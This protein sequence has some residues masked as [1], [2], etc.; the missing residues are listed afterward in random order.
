MTEQRTQCGKSTMVE[1]KEVVQA[2]AT[3]DGVV[4]PAAIN[5]KNP[6]ATHELFLRSGVTRWSPDDIG[7][8]MASDRNQLQTIATVAS[9]AH[10]DSRVRELLDLTEG[11]P[12][13]I[14]ML[15]A[16]CDKND[17]TDA[18]INGVSISYKANSRY[19]GNGGFH[20]FISSVT[21]TKVT[22]HIFENFAPATLA[23][24]R[25]LFL[26]NATRLDLPT[27]RGKLDKSG[28]KQVVALLQNNDNRWREVGA[29]VLKMNQDAT[30]AFVDYLNMN[31]IPDANLNDQWRYLIDK[32]YLLH[33]IDT[34]AD[35]QTIYR[36]PQSNERTI[37]FVR[38]ENA[39]RETA[40]KGFPQ[41]LVR[42]IGEIDGQEI[43]LLSE[44]RYSHG[45]NPFASPEAKYKY[46]DPGHLEIAYTKEFRG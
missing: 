7:F 1:L 25:T 44:N 46:T 36:V 27:A 31:A 41:A 18:L 14:Q 43:S 45:L 39:T 29:L 26:D 38:A 23:S 5:G 2:V 35:S 3:G 37:R 32:S 4:E 42:Y 34:H 40:V 10:H 33:S 20:K 12:A 30:A 28:C 16:A 9:R 15:G 11:T 21:G 6:N 22:G 19:L 17:P 13:T 8:F 24:L